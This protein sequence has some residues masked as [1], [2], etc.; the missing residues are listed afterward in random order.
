MKTLYL[1]R[2]A[3]SSWGDPALDDF[4]RPLNKR[5]KKAAPE[6]ARRLARR[7]VKPDR[8]IASPAKRAK[9]TARHMA[10]GVGLSTEM[11]EY[12]QGLY[13]GTVA[14]HIKVING[15]LAKSDTL[16]IVG[17]NETMTDLAEFL[18]GKYLGNVPTAGIV[19][20]RYGDGGFAPTEGG[21]ELLFFDYPKKDEGGQ[22]TEKE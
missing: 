10:E 16:F 12:D 9:D 21:G 14:Y 5:G 8:V 22:W 1:I 2:H 19:A 17:H 7:G 18:T 15:A 6:M 11:I 13:L 4:D 20:I 3:K